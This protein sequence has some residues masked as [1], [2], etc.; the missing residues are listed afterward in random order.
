MLQIYPYTSVSNVCVGGMVHD[1]SMA[2][3]LTTTYY[4]CILFF[5]FDANAYH[6]T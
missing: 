1:V 5:P 6:V 4:M 2:A 3:L